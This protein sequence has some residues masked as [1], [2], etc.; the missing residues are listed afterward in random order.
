[1]GLLGFGRAGRD[2]DGASLC[3]EGTFFLCFGFFSL[4]SAET[5]LNTRTAS[6]TAAIFFDN[7]FIPPHCGVYPSTGPL[8]SQAIS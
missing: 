2:R 3:G 6:A 1:M 7:R 5:A 4:A 8:P